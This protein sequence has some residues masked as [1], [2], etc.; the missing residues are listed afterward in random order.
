MLA[1]ERLQYIINAL[2]SNKVVL[3]ADLSKEINVSEE[4]IRRDFD[5]L[6][7]QNMICR[8]HGGA[9][10]KDTPIHVVPGKVVSQV[11]NHLPSI[12]LYSTKY[13]EEYDS[14][15][16]DSS[17]ISYEIS[18]VLTRLG[19]N[20][21]LISNSLKIAN[22]VQNHPQ[23]RLIVLGGE[24]NRIH[25]AFFGQNTLREV[26]DYFV[27][28]VFISSAGISVEGG[29]TDFTLE[30]AQVHKALMDQAKIKLYI[31]D[32]HNIDKSAIHVSNT[33]EHITYFIGPSKVKESKLYI[34]L[35]ALDV[36]VDLYDAEFN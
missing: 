12:A 24:M 34:K 16:L 23:I 6:E 8:V 9:Y 7:K 2:N 13:I 30:E 35:K 26:K 19:K 36:N 25:E 31:T 1:V 11:D 21:T 4:T 18:K 20:I 3:V 5:K 10:L 14:I 32:G 17:E 29:I 28:K 33:L 15:Y 22:E 27:D